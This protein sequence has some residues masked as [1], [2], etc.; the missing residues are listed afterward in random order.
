MGHL[1]LVQVKK[2]ILKDPNFVLYMK[3]SNKD[4]IKTPVG[5]FNC[6]IVLPSYMGTFLS[7]CGDPY[8]SNSYNGMP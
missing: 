1:Y 5:C 7:H 3:R 8:I 4:R 6:W 2:V